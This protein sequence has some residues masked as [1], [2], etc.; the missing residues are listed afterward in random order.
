MKGSDFV[1]GV[2]NIEPPA[3]INISFCVYNAA[4]HFEAHTKNNS[5]HKH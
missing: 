1:L 2:G 5:S 4:T 3:F